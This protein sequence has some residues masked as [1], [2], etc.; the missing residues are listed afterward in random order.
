MNKVKDTISKESVGNAENTNKQDYLINYE[1]IE[2]TPFTVATKLNEKVD[3]TE[4]YILLGNFRLNKNAFESK[5]EAIA[6]AKQ[7]TWE[8]IMQVIGIITDEILKEKN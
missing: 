3:I 4:S 7:I 8:R 2:K 5:E 6:D 1:A